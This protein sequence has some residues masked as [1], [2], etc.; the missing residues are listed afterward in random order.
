MRRKISLFVCLT[1]LLVILGAC[2]SGGVKQVESD[3]WIVKF[4]RST[5]SFSLAYI[6]D[7]TQI[8]DLVYSVTGTNIDQEGKAYESHETPFKISGT[9]TDSEKTKDPIQFKINWNNKSEIVT[10]E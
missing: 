4:E 10:F 7:E 8:N 3:H 2:G 5:G 1:I 9:V 6:G